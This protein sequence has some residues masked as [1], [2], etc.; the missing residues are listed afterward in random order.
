MP[1]N[2]P[3]TFR[4]F[5][6]A[7][8]ILFSVIVTCLS[9]DVV[10]MIMPDYYSSAVALAVSVLT[11]LTVAPMLIIDK[12]RRGSIFSYTGVEIGWLTILWI[13]WLGSGS[14]AAW[15]DHYLIIGVP[16]EA[17]CH[18]SD[19]Y[20]YD[21]DSRRMRSGF[22]YKI[23]AIIGFSFFLYLLLMAYTFTLLV[24]TLRA[25]GRG[26]PAWKTSV[27]DGV[28]LRPIEKTTERAILVPVAQTYIISTPYVPATQLTT[29]PQSCSQ[30]P[31]THA[32]SYPSPQRSVSVTDSP[33]T[34]QV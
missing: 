14:F 23:K 18:Y 31:A 4:L 24:L 33:S 2:W 28:L 32:P 20:Y 1:S 15:A 19:R 6:F 34:P 17:T 7:T 8:T 13:F 16:E 22:C 3:F 29:I 9:A 11:I 27:R 5:T 12:L 26:H 10:Y 21:D 30:A 25:K